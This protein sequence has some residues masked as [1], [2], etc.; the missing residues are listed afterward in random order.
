MD[1]RVEQYIA[2][3]KAGLTNVHKSLKSNPTH[4]RSCTSAVKTSISY[5]DHSRIMYDPRRIEER[6]WILNEVQYFAYFD[7]DSGGV[8]EVTAWCERE[9]NRVLTTD[10]SHVVALT[11]LGSAWLSKAQY[12]LARIHREEKACRDIDDASAERRLHTADYVE[13]RAM[14]QPAVDFFARAV[15]NARNQGRLTGPLLEKMAEASMSLGNV[16]SSKAARKYFKEALLALQDA[17]AIGYLLPRHMQ[18][19]LRETERYA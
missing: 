18:Q 9:W 7:P 5:V 4:W 15:E 16:S 2:S 1:P 10:P 3:A 14:L 17:T 19:W 13:A 12:L 11:G 6:V 8:P